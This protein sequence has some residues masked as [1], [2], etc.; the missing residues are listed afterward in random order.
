MSKARQLADLLDS[1]GDV[2]T[3]AL[4]NVPPS[5]DASALTTGTLD[6]AR[7]ADGSIAAGKLT[8]TY[9]T[10]IAD[11]SITDA[12]L[13]SSLDLSGKTVTLPSGVGGK[14]LQVLTDVTTTGVEGPSTTYQSTGLSVSITPSSASNKIVLMC[15][16]TS[17]SDGGAVCH[18]KV[19]IFKGGVEQTDGIGNQ[20]PNNTDGTDHTTSF[21]Y[22]DTAGTT[23]AVTYDIRMRSG[24]G[25]YVRFPSDVNG[26]PQA[27]LI[28]ME[29][30]Q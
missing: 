28:V 2:T 6:A 4:D 27:H 20:K 24:N 3:G 25:G 13:N 1:N 22:S 10:G 17:R 29:I 18:L 21:V 12:K 7:I 11:G 23:S 15:S 8:D 5:N 19:G 16:G 30:A 14:V 26:D 9:L